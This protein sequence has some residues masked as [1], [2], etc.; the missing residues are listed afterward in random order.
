MNTIEQQIYVFNVLQE[1]KGKTLTIPV[2]GRARRKLFALAAFAQPWPY[3]QA[4]FA[5][6]T[7]TASPLLNS[8]NLSHGC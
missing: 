8:L 2:V 1:M 5:N 7:L 3:R 6:A 4:H